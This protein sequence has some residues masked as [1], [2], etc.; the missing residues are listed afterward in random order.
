MWG[1]GATFSCGRYNTRIDTTP[2]YVGSNHTPRRCW[3]RMIGELRRI[4]STRGRQRRGA[5]SALR[6]AGKKG[7]ILGRKSQ[8]RCPRPRT[9]RACQT[10]G[11]QSQEGSA[12]SF[13]CSLRLSARTR[14]TDKRSWEAWSRAAEGTSRRHKEQSEAKDRERPAQGDLQMFKNEAEIGNIYKVLTVHCT[15]RN[16]LYA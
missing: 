3:D 4:R 9:R 13:G 6:A 11:L 16:V 1:R 2:S 10:R 7:R 12:P 14:S 5:L 8:K 15:S